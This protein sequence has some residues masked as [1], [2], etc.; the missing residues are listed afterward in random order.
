MMFA[1]TP[2]EL[3]QA[4]TGLTRASIEVRISLDGLLIGSQYEQ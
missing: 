1:S 4:K 3:S 2:H